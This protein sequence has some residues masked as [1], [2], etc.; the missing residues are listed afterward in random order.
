MRKECFLNSIPVI[1]KKGC[2]TMDR[3]LPQKRIY[4]VDD[5]YAL[6][7]FIR[8]ELFDGEIY[9]DDWTTLIIDEEVF[10]NPPSAEHHVTYRLS[11]IEDEPE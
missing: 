7:D 10:Q 5:I 8:I 2:V 6:P 4:T 9:T 1:N 11:I 3:V